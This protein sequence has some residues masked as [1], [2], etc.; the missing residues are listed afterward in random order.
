MAYN[1]LT[2]GSGLRVSK[3]GEGTLH[4]GGICR[5]TSQRPQTGRG[6]AAGSGLPGDEDVTHG[7]HFSQTA[8]DSPRG[9]YHFKRAVW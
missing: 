5:G 2:E 8:S 4:F 1:R 3:G 7:G 9:A 6:L